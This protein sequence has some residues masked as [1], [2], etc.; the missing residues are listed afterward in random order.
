MAFTPAPLPASQPEDQVLE[1][2]REARE[3]W[4]QTANRHLEFV[5]TP[6]DMA[7]PERNKRDG[8]VDH[9]QTRS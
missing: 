4:A 1:I 9:F 5:S 6:P 2:L 7:S 8:A 3:E